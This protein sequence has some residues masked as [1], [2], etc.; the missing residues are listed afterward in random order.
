MPKV[1]KIRGSIKIGEFIGQLID[2]Q[3][4]NYKYN[5]VQCKCLQKVT[6]T[7]HGGDAGCGMRLWGV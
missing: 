1:T 3:L 7:V 2:C 5:C 4:L 6:L